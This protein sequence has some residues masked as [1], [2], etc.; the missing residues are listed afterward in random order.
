[1]HEDDP[2]PR[3]RNTQAADLRLLERE[4]EPRE[5]FEDEAALDGRLDVELL[6]DVGVAADQLPGPARELLVGRLAR[7]PEVHRPPPLGGL[8]GEPGLEA[9][10]RNLLERVHGLVAQIAA[11]LPDGRLRVG[12][13]PED[14]PDDQGASVSGNVPGIRARRRSR[15]WRFPPGTFDAARRRSGPVR[16]S[17]RTVTFGLSLKCSTSLSKSSPSSSGGTTQ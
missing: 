16:R 12:E 17:T 10:A 1:M 8:V 5:L 2:G 9:K 11:E 4:P 7:L 15:I 3:P 13:V 6:A 14:E